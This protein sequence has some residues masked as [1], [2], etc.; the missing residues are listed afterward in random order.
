[1]QRPRN[2]CA[3]QVEAFTAQNAAFFSTL[4][5]QAPS[6]M[7]VVDARFRILRINARALPVFAA[8]PNALG[9]DISDTMQTLLGRKLGDSIGIF[10]GER[11]RPANALCRRH[12]VKCAAI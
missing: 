7:Y 9:S 1:M 3:E 8:I 12:S 11:W 2:F 5:E 10:C 6:R 4:V